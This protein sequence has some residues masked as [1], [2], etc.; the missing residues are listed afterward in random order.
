MIA[1]SKV[2]QALLGQ[3]GYQVFRDAADLRRLVV[4]KREGAVAGYALYRLRRRDRAV[5]LIQLCVSA[6]AREGGIARLLVDDIARSHPAASGIGAWCREDYEATDAWPRL[7][8]D[9]VGS[10]RGK[11]RSG[12][13]LVH[14]WRPIADR[15]LLVCEPDP[16][17]L[18]VAA[19]DT[20]IFRDLKE[21]RGQH[22]ES[23]ALADAWLTDA[24]EFVITGQVGAEIE[25]A[26]R[27]VARLRGTSSSFR[28][29]SPA[30]EEWEPIKAVLDARIDNPRVDDDDK[31][32]VAQAAAGGAV[33]VVTRDQ[34]LLDVAATV[35]VVTGVQVVRPS[36]LLLR[37]HAGLE[38]ESYQ[39]SAL[40]GTQWSVGADMVVP[41]RQ[42]LKAFLSPGE[43]LAALSMRVN[44]AMAEVAKG[45]RLWTI[46]R[47]GS[48]VAIAVA[49]PE[50]DELVVGVLRVSGLVHQRT[51][52]RQLAHHMRGV[53]SRRGFGRLRVEDAAAGYA[54]RA[55][56]DEGFQ[57]GPD[58]V[59]WAHTRP[60]QFGPT[61]REPIAGR[62]I[63]ELTVADVFESEAQLWPARVITGRTPTYVIPIRPGWALNLLGDD[64]RSPSLLP[65]P[66]A[67]GAAREHV[68][69]RSY[70]PNLTAPARLIWYV[71]GGG[72]E[73]GFRAVSWLTNAVTA[74]PRTLYRRF[75]PRGVYRER[76]VEEVAGPRGAAT[77]LV[78]ARTDLFNR[79]V[80]LQE[81]RTFYSP[82]SNNGYLQS[83]RKVDEHVFVEF[84]QRGLK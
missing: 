78:F 84:V 56:R 55:L 54:V 42:E 23:Q 3:L 50:G 16:D 20:N 19:L 24:V 61:D 63:E 52:A 11:A 2:Y 70:A 37:L 79:A 43:R 58:E 73:G 33:F 40:Y 6:E 27:E 62:L 83:T 28:R 8:F 60:G 5:M 66:D 12:T 59:W 76:D 13:V 77:A 41:S 51:F 35:E 49:V 44:G 32:H 75:G 67:L 31:R 65:R 46:R 80:P 36:Q 38:G 68:Y 22:V 4:A 1:L 34:E 10:R 29:L 26:A 25:V 39:T 64:A 57:L 69:Y 7:G 30:P 71:S 21:P 82:F 53:A 48:P 15:S 18:P 47:D 81:A 74:P 45:A 14:W 72:A 9:R 17:G